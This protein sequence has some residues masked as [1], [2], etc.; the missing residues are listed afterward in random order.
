MKS[1]NALFCLIIFNLSH[2]QKVTLSLF[3]LWIEPTNGNVRSWKK[4]IYLWR[5][6]RIHISCRDELTRLSTHQ[7]HINKMYYSSISSSPPCFYRFNRALPWISKYCLVRLGQNIYS[8]VTSPLAITPHKFYGVIVSIFSY[9]LDLS[10]MYMCTHNIMYTT[11]CTQTFFGFI[12]WC[13]C[14]RITLCT[15]QSVNK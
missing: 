3:V 6:Q 5:R 9:F 7:S 14:V 12:F 11:K 10:L 2:K 15:Q 4:L 13:T 1:E 8:A